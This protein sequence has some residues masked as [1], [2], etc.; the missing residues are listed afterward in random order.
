VTIEDI[1]IQFVATLFGVLIGIP[2]AFWLDRRI[3]AGHEKEKAKGVLTALKAELNHNLDLLRQMQKEFTSGPVII[4]YNMDMNT[5]RGTSLE[6]FEGIIKHKVLRQIFTIYYEYEHLS[7]K[8]DAQFSMH[9][10]VVRAMEYQKE[11]ERIVGAILVHAARLEKATEQLG[12][13]IE[14]ELKRLADS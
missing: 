7:R 11:R 1:A 12:K 6:D 5:W 3:T 14:S 2:A 9:Y 10:S 13:E 8:I 4:Y